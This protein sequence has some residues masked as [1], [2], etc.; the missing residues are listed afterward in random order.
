MHFKRMAVCLLC[1]VF[2]ATATSQTDDKARES[3]AAGI[4]HFQSGDLDA[5]RDEFLRAE[6]LGMRSIS[7][8]YNLAVVY[9]RLGEYELAE[10]RF[11]SLL[12]TDDRALAAYNLGLVALARGE[13]RVAR[14]WF[15]EVSEGGA[16]PNKLQQMAKVQLDRLAAD[17]VPAGHRGQGSGVLNLAGGYDSNI[18]GL[19]DGE[20][21]SKGGSFAE[22]FAVG[23]YR[24]DSFNGNTLGLE[25][26]AYGRR[27]PDDSGYN[28]SLVRGSV[29][30]FE[31]LSEGYREAELTVSQ[32][33]FSGQSFETRYGLEGKRGWRPCAIEDANCSIALAVAR[34]QGASNY[35]AY[36]GQR[37]RLTLA[38]GKQIG[39]WRLDSQ[40]RWDMEDRRDLSVGDQF[41]SLS[42]QHHRLRIAAS[43][44]VSSNLLAGLSGSFRYSRYRDSH[45]IDTVGGLVT[46][47]RTDRRL[48]TTIFAEQWLNNRWLVRAD[49]QYRRS[50]SSIALYDYRRHTVMLSIE[51]IFGSG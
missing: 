11:R 9:Y 4:A 32:S 28:S 16:A 5:A 2:S 23:S 26:S 34:I 33:W 15:S 30:L 45:T 3:L 38:A 46:E 13:Q 39:H 29:F 36:D 27:Y 12:T 37:Y 49:W 40:Y 8:S 21:S 41:Y 10:R 14:A 31:P 22:L 6:A 42:P 50:D 44:P 19:P 24:V 20:L 35:D 47:R 18:A 48:S 25:G 51:G 17:N 7:L 43:V 1:L